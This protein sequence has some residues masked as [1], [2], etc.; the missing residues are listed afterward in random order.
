MKFT[1]CTMLKKIYVLFTRVIIMVL[2]T[3]IH[4]LIFLIMASV[5]CQSFPLS[6]VGQTNTTMNPFPMSFLTP[7][8]D[9]RMVY[10]GANSPPPL[11]LDSSNLIHRIKWL[12]QLGDEPS[13]FTKGATYAKILQLVCFD[14]DL[15]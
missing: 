4:I 12:L 8:F 7:G 9:Q 5:D 13:L 1:N 3:L 11:A 14:I 10:V 15:S 6:W 2:T